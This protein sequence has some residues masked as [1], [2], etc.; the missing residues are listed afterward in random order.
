MVTKMIAA[1]VLLAAMTVP[2]FAGM[3]GG[4]GN[5]GNWTNNPAALHN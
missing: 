1:A 4:T 3:G 2:S 5:T